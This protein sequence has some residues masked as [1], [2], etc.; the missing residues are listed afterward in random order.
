DA[1]RA[2]SAGAAACAGIA[3]HGGMGRRIDRRR[4]STPRSVL[5]A[6][7]TDGAVGQFAW[8]VCLRP[9]AGCTHSAR[10]RTNRRGEVAEIVG[11]ALGG[12][13]TGRAGCRV[14]HALWLE[15]DAGVAKNPD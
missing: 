9:G 3:G 11:A 10:C 5:L 8:R 2:A 1:D 14:L 7:A 15:F 12:I 13:R 4:R 6:A